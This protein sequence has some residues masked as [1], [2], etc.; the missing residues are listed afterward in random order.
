M[1]LPSRQVPRRA[2]MPPR[3]PSDRSWAA[4]GGLGPLLVALGPVLGRSWLL[5]ATL[6]SI[7]VRLATLLGPLGSLLVALGPLWVRSRGGGTQIDWDRLKLG[8]GSFAIYRSKHG[9]ST[10]L[11]TPCLVALITTYQP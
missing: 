10:A 6:G 8:Q 7:L 2:K 5:L 11:L 9:I 4:R 3:W 1:N